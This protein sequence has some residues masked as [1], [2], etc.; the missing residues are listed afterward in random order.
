[1]R[2]HRS[3]SI[4]GLTAILAAVVMAQSVDAL[5]KQAQDEIS[6]RN[7]V[8]AEERLKALLTEDSTHHG[9]YYLMSVVA[10][11]RDNLKGAQQS[12]AT[13]LELD[14][15][16]EEYR[17]QADEVAELSKNM[18]QAGRSYNERNYDDA[19]V[20]YEKIIADNPTFASAYY[21]M[22][23]ALARANQQRQAAE[24]FRQAQ[25][26][27]PDNARYAAALRK[28]VADKYNEGNRLYKARDYDAA[29]EA[30][31]EAYGLDPGFYQAYYR[32]A[33][34]LKNL[35]DTEG[36]LAA[37]D[38]CLRIYPAYIVAYVE[39][40]TILRQ[41]GNDGAAEEVYRQAL[42]V[43]PKA[44]AA[45]VGLGAVLRIDR[46]EE[47]VAAFE[48]AISVN[49]ENASA[50]EYL[51][52]LYSELEDWS[53][54]L[55]HLEKA[56]KLRP[57]SHFTAWR[58]AV[59]YRALGDNE[60]ARLLAKRSTDLNKNFEYAWYE[61]GMAE[62]ALGNRQAAIEAFRNAE[63]GRDAGIRKTSRYELS[64]LETS[65]R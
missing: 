65:N 11:N 38:H 62:K 29:A 30:Y 20:Q 24:A 1:M 58:L 40:G 13:A 15:R 8:L 52:E 3:L 28:L 48:S 7:W 50:N 36:A 25:T 2:K 63:R 55:S 6:V 39:K 35:G 33:R 60:K 56:V 53:E 49:P 43:D 12:I 59:V 4:I 57:K 32:L 5:Y 44:D 23:L 9:A 47:A 26:N 16:N 17:A 22:G 37:L 45:W 27:N 21:G 61:K 18:G 51:G 41:E 54:A 31:Q 10:L 46:T 34:S 64:L 14:E 42:A 19:I